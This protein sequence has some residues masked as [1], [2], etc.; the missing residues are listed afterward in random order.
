VDWMY[1]DRVMSATFLKAKGLSIRD[2][3]LTSSGEGSWLVG[4]LDDEVVGEAEVNH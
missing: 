2:G 3:P 4:A 1:A